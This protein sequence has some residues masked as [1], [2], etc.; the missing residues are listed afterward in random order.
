MEE[1]DLHHGQ[2]IAQ[3]EPVVVE[4]VVNQVLVV[5]EVLVV[6]ETLVQEQ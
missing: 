2:E 6:V 3:Q 4:A 1:Q 5:L